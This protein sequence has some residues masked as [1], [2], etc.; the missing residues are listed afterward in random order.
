MANGCEKM[1]TFA[2]IAQ[3]EMRMTNGERAN[4]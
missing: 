1:Y 4:G 2:N 3:Q